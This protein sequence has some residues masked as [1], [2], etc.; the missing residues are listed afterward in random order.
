MNTGQNDI[1]LI[2][3][4]SK[5]DINLINI[6]S[7]WHQID[8]ILTICSS[9]VRTAVFSSAGAN[10]KRKLYIASIFSPFLL[11]YFHLSTFLWLTAFPTNFPLLEAKFLIGCRVTTC[12]NHKQ[13]GTV[14]NSL[15]MRCSATNAL[16]VPPLLATV[17]LQRRQSKEAEC[18]LSVSLQ[19][20]ETVPNLIVSETILHC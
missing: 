20:S 4:W 14:W 16:I 3:F 12:T 19:Q 11:R 10:R 13:P 8:I 2:S 9:W 17:P 15:R 5:N 18:L 6:W 7:K 1:N